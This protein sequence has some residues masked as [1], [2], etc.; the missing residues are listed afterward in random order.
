MK[1][2]ELIPISLDDKFGFACHKDVPCFN[3]CCKDLNQALTPYDVVR[4]K[5]HLHLTS[6]EFLKRY[7]VVYSGPA[8]GLPVASLRFSADQDH[9]CPF[10]TPDGCKVY[11]AR[12]SSCRIY[13]LARAIRRSRSDGRIT[14]HYAVL[15]EDHCLGFE[16]DSRRTV[17]QWISDQ[18]LETYHRMND[19]MMELIALKNQLHPGELSPE[20]QEMAR[21]AFYDLDTLMEKALSGELPALDHDHLRPLP[22]KNKDEAWLIWSLAWISQVMFGKRI[23]PNVA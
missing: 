13:P 18:K 22:E 16:E 14:E 2:P 10:V 1:E 23:N 15:K 12:P 11:E 8:T 21:M 9:N 17:R 19:A 20:H 7:A 6:R 5:K 3:H 4:L